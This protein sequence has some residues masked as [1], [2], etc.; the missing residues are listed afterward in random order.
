MSAKIIEGMPMAQYIA[1]PGLSKHGLDLFSECPEKFQLK[2]AGLIQD[3]PSDAM[4]FGRAVHSAVFEAKRDYY[5]QPATYMDGD[6]SKPW[7]GNSKVCKQ[8]KASHTDRPVL[9]LEDDQWIDSLCRAIK[10]H[11]LASSLIGAGRAELSIFATDPETG[12]ALKG[13]PDWVSAD[14]KTVVDLKTTRKATVRACRRDVNEYRYHVQFAMYRKLLQLAGKEPT[15]FYFIFVETGG[16]MPILNVRKLGTPSLSLADAIIHDELE[17]FASC[18][19]RDVW[20]GYSGESGAVEDIE[21]P[22]YAFYEG[23][24][25]ATL[26]MVS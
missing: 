14:W 18:Q 22:D 2:Q 10:L 9:N 1:A 15:G 4:L 24:E 16:A 12:V 23:D 20:P 17:R 13:R 3:K 5:I 19:R 21:V 6:E 8:W 26:D 25:A 7:N 11:P